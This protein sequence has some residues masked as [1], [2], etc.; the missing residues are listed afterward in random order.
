M[1]TFDLPIVLI[2]LSYFPLNEEVMEL[3]CLVL[4]P[5]CDGLMH[6]LGRRLRSLKSD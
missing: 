6:S 4:T 2:S 3:F 5:G 1:L